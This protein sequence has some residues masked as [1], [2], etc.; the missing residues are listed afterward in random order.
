[1]AEPSPIAWGPAQSITGD[2]DVIV[3]GALIYA[4]SFTAPG[5]PATGPVNGVA[6]Q[7]FGIPF[8]SQTVTVGN[9]TISEPDPRRL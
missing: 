3:T 6:F 5:S 9:V 8:D 1:M 4:Y 7:P 2:S